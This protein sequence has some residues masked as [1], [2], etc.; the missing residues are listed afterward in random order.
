[1]NTEYVYKLHELSQTDK[2][3]QITTIIK[4]TKSIS[5]LEFHDECIA[6]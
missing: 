2:K 6:R 1:M 3:T 5:I 4:R